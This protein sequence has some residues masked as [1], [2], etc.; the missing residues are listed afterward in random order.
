[1]VDRIDLFVDRLLAQ[2]SGVTKVSDVKSTSDLRKRGIPFSKIR[3]KVVPS[4]D[5]DFK[6]ELK[7]E[8]SGSE[9]E[10]E[11]DIRRFFGRK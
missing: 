2:E 4:S 1:M 8:L 10:K 7:K 3:T 6:S 9:P 5:V 11:R